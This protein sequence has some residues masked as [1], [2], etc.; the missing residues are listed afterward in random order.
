M[1]GVGG[2]QVQRPFNRCLCQRWLVATELS[3]SDLLTLIP[4][5]PQICLDL[6][7]LFK[8]GAYEHPERRP[9]STL[10]LHYTTHFVLYF[11]WFR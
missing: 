8:Y 5:R 10:H 7:S 3:L 1:H 9:P 2:T 4:R 11:C 6:S